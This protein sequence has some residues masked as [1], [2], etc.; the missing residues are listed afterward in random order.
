VI[1]NV[2]SP[3]VHDK[4]MAVG[5]RPYAVSKS[6]LACALEHLAEEV[7]RQQLQI[8]NYHPGFIFSEGIQATCSVD[9]FDWD[10]GEFNPTQRIFTA[11]WTD[12]H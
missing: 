12:N 7:P 10:D 6:A 9:D 5:Y 3:F 4:D 11:L 2:S 8:I 1:V